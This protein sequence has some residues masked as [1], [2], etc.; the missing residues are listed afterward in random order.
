MNM[1]HATWIAQAREHWK[2]HLPKMYARLKKAGTLE[3]ELTKAAD[4]TAAQMQ[5]LMARG[6]PHQD[7]WEMSREQYLFRPEEPEQTPKM[8]KSAGYKAHVA[9]LK[10]LA[11]VGQPEE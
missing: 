8:P 11:Q 5:H 2:E 10:A 7:A 9:Y 4:A 6:F 3:Q 1:Q